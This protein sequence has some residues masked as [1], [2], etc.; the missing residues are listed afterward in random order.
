MHREEATFLDR[1]RLHRSV[2][3]EKLIGFVKLVADETRTQAGLMNIVSMIAE[4]DKAPT[5]ALIAQASSIMR[6]ARDQLSRLFTIR[7]WK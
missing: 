3:Q 7:L 5:N 2:S 1:E 4:R 6:K